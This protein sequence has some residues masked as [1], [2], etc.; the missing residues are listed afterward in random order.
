MHYLI[1]E[2]ERTSVS[3]LWLENFLDIFITIENECDL[4]QVEMLDFFER[5]KHACAH[6]NINIMWA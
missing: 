2:I 3:N 4:Y 1:N 6:K 5:M